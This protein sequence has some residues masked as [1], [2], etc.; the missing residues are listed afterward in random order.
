MWMGRR[1]RRRRVRRCGTG[2]AASDFAGNS[3]AVTVVG[4]VPD[5]RPL[6]AR[7]QD[8]RR[9]RPAPKKKSLHPV[10]N[11]TAPELGVDTTVVPMVGCSTTI[12]KGGEP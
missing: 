4:A 9:V 5:A 8:E 6:A 11:G 10:T 7:T 1:G 3:T 12:G 2:P